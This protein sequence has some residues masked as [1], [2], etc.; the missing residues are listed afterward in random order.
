MFYN[1]FLS[2]ALL[3]GAATPGAMAA[4]SAEDPISST[5]T[6]NNTT[7]TTITTPGPSSLIDTVKAESGSTNMLRGAPQP[8]LGKELKLEDFFAANNN[9]DRKLWEAGMF[10]IQSS[11]DNRYFY[12]WSDGTVSFGNDLGE[13]F[14]MTVAPGGGYFIH[15]EYNGH[16]L[17][18]NF[19][20]HTAYFHSC[21]GGNNQKWHFYGDSWSNIKIVSEHDQ[22]CLDVAVY[23][24]WEVIMWDC[25]GG[26]NQQFNILHW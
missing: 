25:H 19:N 1:T 22:K 21:H 5:K 24:N 23:T 11:Y 17:D 9:G 13:F 20:A 14:Y 26:A 3:V 6:P 18:N 2:A 7:A 12:S 16:C 4:V 8:L 15:M 10:V